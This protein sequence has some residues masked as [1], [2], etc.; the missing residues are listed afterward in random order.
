MVKPLHVV[1]KCV[2]FLYPAKSREWLELWMVCFEGCESERSVG[3]EAWGL[4]LCGKGASDSQ[5]HNGCVLPFS[6]IALV[7]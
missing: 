4:H 7:D 3:P 1:A 5:W 2:Q 6:K